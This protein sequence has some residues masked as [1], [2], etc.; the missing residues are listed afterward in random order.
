MIFAAAREVESSGGPGKTMRLTTAGSCSSRCAIQY[1]IGRPPQFHDDVLK[2]ITHSLRMVFD[3]DSTVR[4]VH[5][6]VPTASPQ[7]PSYG[8]D[9]YCSTVVAPSAARRG[10]EQQAAGGVQAAGWTT[11]FLH[12]YLTT[13][14]RAHEESIE[15]RT[16][17]ST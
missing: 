7:P 5:S 10:C 3:D 1:E 12:A 4:R 6:L 13:Y 14:Q 11:P 15:R 2:V 9:A 16:K 8:D 17:E